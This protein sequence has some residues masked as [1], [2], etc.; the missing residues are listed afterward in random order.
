[1]ESGERDCQ[2]EGLT[3]FDKGREALYGLNGMPSLWWYA[4]RRKL[5]YFYLCR[6]HE[7]DLAAFM[8]GI[9]HD[10]GVVASFNQKLPAEILNIPSRGIV[11]FHPSLL[12][13]F[14]GPFTW[15][16]EYYEN[17]REGGATV[18]FLDEGEDTGDIIHQATYPIPPGMPPQELQLKAI[19][20]GCDLLVSALDDI[21]KGS[22]K[23]VPQRDKPCPRRARYLKPGEDLFAW[24]NWDIE[25]SFH[26]LAG[27]YPWYRAINTSHGWAGRLPWRATGYQACGVD[28]PGKI[29]WD[30]H[31]VYF[32]HSEGKIRLKS[33]IPR[34]RIFLW[35]GLLAALALAF[36]MPH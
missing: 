6:G 11:N 15:F 22:V 33:I 19:A 25:H 14:R 26:F 31:G 29:G 8:R 7:P 2:T 12:P 9:E 3:F 23:R 16:W 27:V 34:E 20:L 35:I 32:A 17:E 13:K 28:A 36:F 21:E 24:Q 18:H 5:P 4:R 10:V 1:M 30:W